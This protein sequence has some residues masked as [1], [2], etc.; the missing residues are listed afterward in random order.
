M[1]PRVYHYLLLADHVLG[2]FFSVVLLAV[3]AFTFSVTGGLMKTNELRLVGGA[4]THFLAELEA[5]ARQPSGAA[6]DRA[7]R[8]ERRRSRAERTDLACEPDAECR[9]VVVEILTVSFDREAKRHGTS[10]RRVGEQWTVFVAQQRVVAPHL[11][12]AHREIRAACGN[13][14][15][16]SDRRCSDG[17]DI[18][19]CERRAA[20]AAA[21]AVR[22]S[23]PRASLRTSPQ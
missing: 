6:C 9:G 15:G 17:C 3:V 20:I 14:S 11:A 1:Y 12:D 10:H 2:A 7:T 4:Y 8:R 22:D 16:R 18:L 23:R 19:F 21:A 13:E 5:E